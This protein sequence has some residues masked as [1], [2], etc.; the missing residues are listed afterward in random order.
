MGWQDTAQICLNGHL[1]NST[2]QD[3]SHKNQKFCDRCGK[4]TIT[5]CMNCGVDVKGRYHYD[6][7][8]NF[9]GYEIPSYCHNCGSPYPWT[10]EKINAAKEYVDF[11][12][13]LSDEEKQDLKKNIDDIISDT[14]RSKLASQK[15]K[16]HLPKVGKSLAIGFKDILVDVASETAKKILL[17]S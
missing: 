9:T 17:E 12:E 8:A 15:I 11:M 14:P 6:R 10:A 4:E 16:H 7:V 3:S 13:E 1:I 2:Y 5:E